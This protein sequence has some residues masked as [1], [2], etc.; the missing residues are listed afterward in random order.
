MANYINANFLRVRELEEQI[1][2]LHQTMKQILEKKE[3]EINF[4]K[5]L[6]EEVLNSTSWK[7][8]KPL[9]KISNILKGR[10]N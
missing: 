9:R 10:G 7:A 4:Y 1:N 6:S 3:Q 8:T 5:S 2:N